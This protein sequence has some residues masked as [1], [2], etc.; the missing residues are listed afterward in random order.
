MVAVVGEGARVRESF[1]TNVEEGL[2][3][4]A[5]W[6]GRAGAVQVR[7]VQHSSGGAVDLVLILV[8]ILVLVDRTCKVGRVRPAGKQW[9]ALVC[10]GC[11]LQT[12]SRQF[13]TSPGCR[14]SHNTTDNLISRTL[15]PPF[16][17]KFDPS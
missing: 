2:E 16:Y 3:D 7:A 15:H 13:Q 8:L 5:G 10:K 6:Y 11:C 4:D 14:P 17:P 9:R 12:A 1:A